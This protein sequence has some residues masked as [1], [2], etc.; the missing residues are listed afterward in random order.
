QRALQLKEK[1]LGPEHPDVA[2]TLNNLATLRIS[3]L[4]FAEAAT[5]Y[6]R[7]LAIFQTVF[8]PGHPKVVGCEKNYRCV[9][10]AL[11][12]RERPSSRRSQALARRRS[13]RTV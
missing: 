6:Q 8:G 2:I 7:A 10:S 4:R 1:L 5:M 3:Q 9:L 12:C 13:W 11:E